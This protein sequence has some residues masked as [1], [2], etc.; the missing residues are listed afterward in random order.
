MQSLEQIRAQ[1][2][3]AKAAEISISGDKD[4]FLSLARSLPAMLQGNGLLATWAFLLAKDSSEHKKVRQA[5][6]QHLCVTMHVP[7]NLTDRTVLD[8]KSV[9]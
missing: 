8:R 6:F 2:A 9:V 5:L 1:H 4:S 7:E 3:Y